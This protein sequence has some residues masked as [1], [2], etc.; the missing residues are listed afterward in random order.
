[1]FRGRVLLIAAMSAP[2]LAACANGVSAD[3]IQAQ[4]PKRIHS[5]ASVSDLVLCLKA[6]LE[7]DANIVAYPEPGKVDVRVGY[8]ESADYRYFY[9]INLR[10]AP[11]GTNVEIRSSGEWRPLL[12]PGRVA[13]MV[14]NCKPGT[15]H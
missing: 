1:M 14:E 8:A 4:E 2:L 7:E 9:L 5:D 11:Q 3:Y 13:G 12:S 10:R 6:K 15:A